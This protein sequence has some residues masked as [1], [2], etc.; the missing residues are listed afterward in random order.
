MKPDEKRKK[1]RFRPLKSIRWRLVAYLAVF[2]IILIAILWIFQIVFLDSIY[3]KIKVTEIYNTAEVLRREVSSFGPSSSL[4]KTIESLSADNQIC[5]QVLDYSMR[6]VSRANHD[7]CYSIGTNEACF[8]HAYSGQHFQLSNMGRAYFLM[9]VRKSGEVFFRDTALAENTQNNSA[10]GMLYVEFVGEGDS[11]YYI[12]LNTKVTPVSATVN[13]LK[14]ERYIISAVFVLLAVVLG[15]ILS[16]RISSP[17]I[18]INDRAKQLATGDYSTHFDGGGY[19]E[20]DE[21]RNTLN[22]AA[23]ELSKVEGFRRELLANISHDLRTPLTMITGY[24]EVMR[25]LPGENTPENVQVII[26]EANRLTMLVNDLLDLS[27][28]QSGAA[29]F[30]PSVFSLTDCVNSIIGRYQK[31]KENDGYRIDFIPGDEDVCVRADY[32]KLQQVIY[33]LVNNAISYTGDDKSVLIRQEIRMH[34][35]VKRVRISVTDTG[36]G[37]SPENLEYIWDRYFKENKAHKRAVVGTGLGLSIVKGVLQMH[38]AEYG[39][40]SSE[41]PENHGSTFW[42]EM[43]TAEPEENDI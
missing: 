34:E 20:I 36:S 27:K 14:I 28:L 26:D 9:L 33:N 8:V 21:L 10:T 3:K 37:I 31:L 12:I 23:E 2:V 39:V 30:S 17:I 38:H 18:K 5:I 25:D 41:K 40:E 42:F 22:Y 24:S 13:T 43:E 7:T 6:D 35:N 32:S 29:S 16:Y 19:A 11:G 4:D 15:L 1:D